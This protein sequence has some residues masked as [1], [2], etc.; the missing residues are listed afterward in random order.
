MIEQVIATI[1]DSYE[2]DRLAGNCSA[3]GGRGNEERPDELDPDV[4]KRNTRSIS[5]LSRLGPN[6]LKLFSVFT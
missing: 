4:L 6:R 1:A 3:P 2:R 5:G